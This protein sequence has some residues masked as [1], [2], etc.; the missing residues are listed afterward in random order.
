MAQV[1]HVGRNAVEWT[2]PKTGEVVR[3]RLTGKHVE[4]V[5]PDG[6]DLVAAWGEG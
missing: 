1:R 4:I 6:R 3:R 2:R 5:A